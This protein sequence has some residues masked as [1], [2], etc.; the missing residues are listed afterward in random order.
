MQIVPQYRIIDMLESY[1]AMKEKLKMYE[2]W[3]FLSNQFEEVEKVD[4]EKVKLKLPNEE[5]LRKEL[6]QCRRE[7]QGIERFL[8]TMSPEREDRILAVMGMY[9]PG[10]EGRRKA[11]YQQMEY[12]R[13]RGFLQAPYPLY[14]ANATPRWFSYSIL[15]HFFPMLN[16]T[17]RFNGRAREFLGKF[18]VTFS[19]AATLESL[20]AISDNG[21]YPCDYEHF[22]EKKK[23]EQEALRIWLKAVRD[24]VECL[25]EKDRAIVEAVFL[26]P[27]EDSDGNVI[28][29]ITARVNAVAPLFHVSPSTLIIDV[30]KIIGKLQQLNVGFDELVDSVP[31]SGEQDEEY[32]KA[33]YHYQ[34]GLVD[35]YDPRIPVFHS[36]DEE[37]PESYL[38]KRRERK[39]EMP[40][41]YGTAMEIPKRTL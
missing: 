35:S 13:K 20:L 23:E 27:P 10:E 8:A 34:E 30:K 14:V 36:D 16:K 32:A 25:N 24:E 2:F 21:Y 29:D 37:P 26:N 3:D 1:P 12:W 6:A 40:G 33:L 5:Q 15:V 9:G 7:I 39:A 19:R 11:Y 22:F 4:D 38:S 41:D 18:S 17:T 28:C 31:L